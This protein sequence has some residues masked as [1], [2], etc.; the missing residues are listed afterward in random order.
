MPV[1]NLLLLI[2][3]NVHLGRLRQRRLNPGDNAIGHE[4]DMFG[5]CMLDK[6]VLAV[7]A[8]STSI[9]LVGLL[10]RVAAF[11]IIA[12]AN[13]REPLRTV[14]ALVGLL[15]GVDSHMHQKITPLIELFAA[16]TAFELLDALPIMLWL[17][18]RAALSSTLHRLL[19]LSPLS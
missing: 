8:Y 12:V 4:L 5:L 11:M 1:R 9:A 16:V 19:V 7:V 18:Q 3:Q 13:C 17:N 2:D 6:L 14:F 15:A 10:I